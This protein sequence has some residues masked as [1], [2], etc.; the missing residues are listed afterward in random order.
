MSYQ[1]NKTDGTLLASLID[2][3]IETASTNLTF[4]GKN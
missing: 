4:V 1:L 3:Q 2:G